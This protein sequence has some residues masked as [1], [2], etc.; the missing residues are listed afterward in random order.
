MRGNRDGQEGTG[1][2]RRAGLGKVVPGDQAIVGPALHNM[3]VATRN[4]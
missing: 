2:V 4:A 3:E 1:K